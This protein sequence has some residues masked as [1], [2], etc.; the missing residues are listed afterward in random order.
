MAKFD[1]R[2]LTVEHRWNRDG[3]CSVISEYGF[4][5]EIQKPLKNPSTEE[6]RVV[7]LPKED[8][9]RGYYVIKFFESDKS[10]YSIKYYWDV[11]K[12]EKVEEYWSTTEPIIDLNDKRLY[13]KW[14]V[15]ILYNHLLNVWKHIEMELNYMNRVDLNDRPREFY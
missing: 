15:D 14:A 3:T 6:V 7:I 11:S 2:R 10:N 13:M 4:R 12:R 1:W 5:T 8:S 9:W